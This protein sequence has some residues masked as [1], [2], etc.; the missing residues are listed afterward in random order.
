PLWTATVGLV[1]AGFG[2]MTGDSQRMHQG[3][4]LMTTLATMWFLFFGTL[5]LFSCILRIVVWCFHKIR[6]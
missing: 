5:F 3:L 2:W 6:S 4:A 1:I